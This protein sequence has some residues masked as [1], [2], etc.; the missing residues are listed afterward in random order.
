VIVLGALILISA[1]AAFVIFNR[2]GV[3]NYIALRRETQSLRSEVDSLQAVR[4]SLAE[5]VQRLRSDSSYMERMVREVLGWGRPGEM[6]I[7]FQLP[8]AAGETC[9]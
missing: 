1:L 4:D 7:R 2:N 6:I 3:L 5:E 8:S 9:P